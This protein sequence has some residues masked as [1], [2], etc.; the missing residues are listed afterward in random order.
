MDFT[1][2]EPIPE[3]LNLIPDSRDLGP[4]HASHACTYAR[5]AG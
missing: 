1:A 2:P 5:D 4:E 3:Y